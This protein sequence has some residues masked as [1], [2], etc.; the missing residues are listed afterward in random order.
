MLPRLS[1]NISCGYKTYRIGISLPVFIR[2][3]V[4]RLAQEIWE[5]LHV[6]FGTKFR[7]VENVMRAWFCEYPLRTLLNFRWMADRR[8]VCIPW[9]I[10]IHDSG[11]PYG[12]KDRF[13]RSAIASFESSTEVYTVWAAESAFISRMDWRC[14]FKADSRFWALYIDNSR[15]DRGN[16]SLVMVM[17]A[18]VRENIA[19]RRGSWST[20]SRGMS[21][22]HSSRFCTR[23]EP[24]RVC[25]TLV[26]NSCMRRSFVRRRDWLSASGI[27]TRE[28]RW[29]AEP[30]RLP[31]SVDDGDSER[32]MASYKAS[33][34]QSTLWR[35]HAPCD[36]YQ[37]SA[38]RNQSVYDGR[39]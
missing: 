1:G 13:L 34:S 27:T 5:M 15:L 28:A 32:K 9:F 36:F 39:K 3:R 18:I 20:A 4:V 10:F 31:S 17:Y 2:N 29:P 21:F 22:I 25:E 16:S 14:C 35:V 37:L 26:T 19:Y 7:N 8:M 24:G 12:S 30:H 23:Y 38:F 11:G 6:C 33:Y